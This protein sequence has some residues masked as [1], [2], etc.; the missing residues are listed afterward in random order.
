MNEEL[1]VLV[2]ELDRVVG[3]TP[4]N[5][6]HTMETPLHRAFSS[7]IFNANGEL[8]LQQRSSK[9]KTW[10]LSW[11]NSCCG[12]P[13]VDETREDAL[14]RRARDELGLELA[15]IKMVAPYRY[16]FE[17]D[18]VVENEICPIF[19]AK[20][21]NEPVLNP[22]EVEKIE[23]ISWDEFLKDMEEKGASKYSDWCIEEVS[24]LKDNA[25]FK[26][27]LSSF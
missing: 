20:A 11:S 2:D 24:I 1:V 10:P 5:D 26:K 23:W 16:R 7:F 22:D 13:G 9:K 4:K 12:H 17:K 6:V 21:K 14:I 3:T 15:D 19:I 8:L 27:F 25:E 18:G